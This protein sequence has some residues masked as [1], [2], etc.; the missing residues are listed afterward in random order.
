MAALGDGGAARAAGAVVQGL[1]AAAGARGRGPLGQ[2]LARGWDRPSAAADLTAALVL[3]ADHDLNVSS[4]TARCVASADAPLESAL[5]AALCALRGRRHG[6]MAER[7]E[8]L[9]RDAGRDGAREA[10]A[11][12]LREQGAL[13]GFGHELYPDGDPRGAELAA[14]RRRRP[15]DPPVAAVVAIARGASSASSRRS[16]WGSW[17]CLPRPPPARGRAALPLRARALGG[18]GGA[19]AGGGRRRAPDPAALALHRAGAGRPV[20]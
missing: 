12:A 5:L 6:G 17:R 2:R 18:L 16:T 1:F 13:P 8:G 15:D 4:F 20:G 7:V 11:R 10:V 14:A 3:C 19:R 9:L